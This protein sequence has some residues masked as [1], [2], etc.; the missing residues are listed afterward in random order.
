[1]NDHCVARAI[2]WFLAPGG[3]ITNVVG[4]IPL[5]LFSVWLAWSGRL[6]VRIHSSE[7]SD[8]I[9]QNIPAAD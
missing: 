3:M 2:T 4:W 5:V 6:P 7:G 9:A 8:E 1:M